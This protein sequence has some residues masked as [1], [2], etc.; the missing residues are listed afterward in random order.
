[1]PIEAPSLEPAMKAIA[2]TGPTGRVRGLGKDVFSWDALSTTL[3]IL[4]V[5]S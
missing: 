2:T 1:M 3:K 5:H 4:T